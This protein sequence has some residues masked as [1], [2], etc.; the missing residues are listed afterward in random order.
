[1]PPRQHRHT[2][3]AMRSV[4]DLGIL[5]ARLRG[6]LTTRLGL[7]NFVLLAVLLALTLASRRASSSQPRVVVADVHVAHP[8]VSAGA[9][10][11]AAAVVVELGGWP[12]RDSTPLIHKIAPLLEQ[13]KCA[14][15]HVWLVGDFRT[16][17][18]PEWQDAAVQCTTQLLSYRCNAMAITAMLEAHVRTD[19]FLIVQAD[20]FVN[21]CSMSRLPKDKFWIQSAGWRQPPADAAGT[22]EHVT[23]PPTKRI[24]GWDKWSRWSWWTQTSEHTNPDLTTREAMV[25]AYKDL[26]QRGLL[27]P[28][29]PLDKSQRLESDDV[30]FVPHGVAERYVEVAHVIA[31]HG[32]FHEVGVALLWSA[33]HHAH[34]VD[35]VEM[36]TLGGCCVEVDPNLQLL[37]ADCAHK[38]SIDSIPVAA[39][40]LSLCTGCHG[41]AQGAGGA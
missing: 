8:D 22:C 29:W 16:P 7:V 38:L 31:A 14:F 24:W 3:V 37:A 21:P 13:Y 20:A 11:L 25:E 1:M 9:T 18:P 4:C 41:G 40:M 28:D 17:V 27:P 19:G 34:G 36:D 2:A 12:G 39:K 10:P 6:A 35:C 15:P 23:R 33:L 32:V 5:R 30:K 26:K